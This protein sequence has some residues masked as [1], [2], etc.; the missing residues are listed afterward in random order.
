M[1]T[2]LELLTISAVVLST[3]F[4]FSILLYGIFGLGAIKGPDDFE[5]YSEK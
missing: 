3:G 5:I 2:I 4:L 1:K